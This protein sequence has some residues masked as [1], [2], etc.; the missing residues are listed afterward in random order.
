MKSDSKQEFKNA[1]RY[2]QSS[3]PG[4]IRSKHI[5]TN[6]KIVGLKTAF[7]VLFCVLCKQMLLPLRE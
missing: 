6:L 5:P 1:E 7:F 2:L 4:K 3:T